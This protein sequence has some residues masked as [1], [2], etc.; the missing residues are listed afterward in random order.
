MAR[1]SG[2]LSHS[3][4]VIVVNESDWSVEYNGN[5]SA[6]NYII[7]GLETSGNKT[8]IARLDGGEAMGYGNV[9]VT[10]AISTPFIDS[11]SSGTN[12]DS[13]Y[14]TETNTNNGNASITS[15]KLRLYT[16]S[17]N[18]NTS[19]SKVSFDKYTISSNFQID[20]DID[21]YQ[22]D[23]QWEGTE[24]TSLSHHFKVEIDSTHW[25][26]YRYFW[27]WIGGSGSNGFRRGSVIDYQL[28]GSVMSYPTNEPWLNPAPHPNLFTVRIERAGANWSFKYKIGDTWYSPLSNIA[29]GS[30]DVTN[31]ELFA[32][33]YDNGSYGEQIV[34]FDNFKIN[35]GI[36]DTL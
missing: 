35:Y 13:T 21:L 14:W 7:S 27:T 30:G 10:G 8:V 20:I 5:K 18:N 9:T 16:L 28:G 15:S 29:I 36:I 25:M 34:D 23:E 32:S 24:W 2:N 26:K 3:A 33:M 4:R 6:G 11:F 31:V 19:T 1:I 17:Q 22:V 12:P